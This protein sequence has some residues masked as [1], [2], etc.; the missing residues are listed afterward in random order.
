MPASWRAQLE[1]AWTRRIGWHLFAAAAVAALGLAL[2][3]KVGEDVFAHE[4]GSFDDVIRSW[5]LAHQKPWIFSL[6]TGITNAGSS[7][8]IGIVSLLIGAWLWRSRGRRAASGAIVAPLLAY[9]LFNAIKLA[10]GRV[11]PTGALHFGLHSFAFPSGHATVSMAASVTAAYVLWR[12][13]VIPGRG[14]AAIAIVI[15]LLVGLSRVYLDVHWT[16][17][18]LGGW[19][20]G[21]FVAGLSV[22]TYEHLRRDPAIVVDEPAPPSAGSD[23]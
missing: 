3:A 10:Y 2:S 5:I 20:V 6:F 18:V 23:S 22:A 8:P 19:S 15:P 4:S 14:A 12:E 9:A 11:R 17:D 7:I 1:R 16:T 21:L 13:R